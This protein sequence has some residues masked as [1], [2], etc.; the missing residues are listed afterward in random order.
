MEKN[1][2]KNEQEKGVHKEKGNER[3]S[4][5][6]GSNSYVEDVPG[7]K[8]TSQEGSKDS[9]SSNKGENTGRNR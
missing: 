1:K 6:Q 8:K 7:A 3:T 4:T 2:N 9:Q 5:S